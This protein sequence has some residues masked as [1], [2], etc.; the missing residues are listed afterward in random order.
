MDII[1]IKLDIL[2]HLVIHIVKHVMEAQIRI[3]YL[4]MHH[5]H[6]IKINVLLIAQ[7]VTEISMLYVK[8]V[9]P[10][11]ISVLEHNQISVY[12]VVLDSIS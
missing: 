2:V 9:H 11:V 1:I 6:I 7:V 3:A 10:I 12:F 5:W 4:A 8:H